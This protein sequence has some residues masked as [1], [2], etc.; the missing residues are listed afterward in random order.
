MWKGVRRL[1]YEMSVKYENG[2]AEE[3]EIVKTK[4]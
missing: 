4:F 3:R 2:L 1:K